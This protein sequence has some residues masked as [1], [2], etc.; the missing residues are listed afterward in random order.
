MIVLALSGC[1]LNKKAMTNLEII[2]STYEAFEKCKVIYIIDK[3]ENKKGKFNI[4]E[5]TKF[6]SY[7]MGE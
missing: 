1:S 3:S 7:H 5:V 6:S 2:K 4:Y